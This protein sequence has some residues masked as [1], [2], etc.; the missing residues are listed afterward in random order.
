MVWII[1]H[2]VM[3][4][5]VVYFSYSRMDVICVC[6]NRHNQW[7]SEKLLTVHQQVSTTCQGSG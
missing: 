2:Q 5:Q 1:R 6:G 3:T 7:C 4:V